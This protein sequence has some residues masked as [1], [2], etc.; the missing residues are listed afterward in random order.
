VKITKIHTSDRERVTIRTGRHENH[1]K[2]SKRVKIH[3]LDREKREKREKRENHI[4]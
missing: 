1:K 4:L 3:I 2:A